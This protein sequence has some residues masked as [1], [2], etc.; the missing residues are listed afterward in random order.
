M[1]VGGEFAYFKVMKF[2]LVFLKI[3]FI[4]VCMHMSHTLVC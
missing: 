4:H 3:T 1:G 2:L